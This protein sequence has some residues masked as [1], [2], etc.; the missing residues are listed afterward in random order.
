MSCVHR[1]VVCG[2]SNHVGSPRAS[3]GETEGDSY[4]D[5]K[6]YWKYLH[7]IKKKI[8]REEGVTYHSC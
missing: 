4:H 1:R 3:H 6:L 7:Q 8:Y 2:H 5:T